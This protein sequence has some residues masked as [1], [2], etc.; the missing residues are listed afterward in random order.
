M[1]T[2]DSMTKTAA[3]DLTAATRT[4]LEIVAQQ[5]GVKVTVNGGSYNPESGTFRPKVEYALA[6]SDKMTWDLYAPMEGL[7]ASDFGRT[8]SQSGFTF[9]IDGF[10]PKSPK[11]PVIA[12]KVGTHSRF[13]FTTEA[14][15]AALRKETA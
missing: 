15:K 9:K 14:V 7:A 13:K 12:T 11:R 5:L 8:F 1:S 3:K 10:S 4:A 2:I 6:D